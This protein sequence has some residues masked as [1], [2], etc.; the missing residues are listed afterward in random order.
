VSAPPAAAGKPAAVPQTIDHFTDI[1]RRLREYGATYYA[2]ETGGPQG[3]LYRF[4]CK[5]AD[6]TA[7]QQALNFE[8]T[9]RDALHAMAR[10]MDEVEAWHS[11]TAL[12]PSSEPDGPR[13]R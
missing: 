9:D 10:V 6:A 3:E 2:L 5:M 12:G 11:K 4:Q 1:Q 8:A 13:L 7:G